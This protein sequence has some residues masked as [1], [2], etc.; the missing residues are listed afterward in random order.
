MIWKE[1]DKNNDNDDDDDDGKF[2]TNR[3]GSQPF[4]WESQHVDRKKKKNNKKKGKSIVGRDVN[5]IN[6]N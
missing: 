5:R 2:S 6:S 1:N 3:W 4:E